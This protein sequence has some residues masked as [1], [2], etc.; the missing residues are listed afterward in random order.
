M[1][2]LV[3][4][5][6]IFPLNVEAHTQQS[7]HFDITSQGQEGN[8]AKW[9]IML[10]DE[11]AGQTIK[12]HLTGHHALNVASLASQHIEVK[13][14]GTDYEWTLPDDWTAQSLT[15]ST[16]LD[17]NQLS[18]VS[19][20]I[21]STLDGERLAAQDTLYQYTDVTGQ[22]T[23]DKAVQ[24]D[25]QDVAVQLVNQATDETVAEQRVQAGAFTFKDV[26]MFNDDGQEVKYIVRVAE[27]PGYKI[28]VD[29]YH[30][31]IQ[32]DK[33]SE[34]RTEETATDEIKTEEATTPS[35][36]E[37]KTDDVT[38]E[39]PT[40]E[41]VTTESPTTETPV[42][43]AA[44]KSIVFKPQMR[45][46]N[47]MALAA[48][49]S[50]YSSTPSASTINIATGT[51]NLGLS[52]QMN[53]NNT[54]ITW[55]FTLDYETLA[56][57]PVWLNDIAVSSGLSMPSSVS[58][59]VVPRSG[60]IKS[61]SK[62]VTTTNGLSSISLGDV[63]Q[64]DF[65]VVTIVT[66]VTT[67]DLSSYKLT[68]GRLTYDEIGY[69]YDRAGISN[70]I[71]RQ[72]LAPTINTVTE[73]AR[74]VT[75]TA[76]AGAVVTLKNASGVTIGTA[77]ADSSGKYSMSISPQ[78]KG[79]VLMASAQ[80]P[81]QI[82][83][84]SVSTTVV[85]L[86]S[87]NVLKVDNNQKPLAGAVFTL[88]GPTTQQATSNSAGSAQFTALQPGTY[89]LTETTAPN[90]YVRN[91]ASKTV[92]VASNGAVTVD[93]TAV[94]GS[95]QYVN[96]PV[97]SS[98]RINAV[99]GLSNK[100]VA[101]ATYELRNAA[102]QLVATQTSD[103]SGVVLFNN[104]PLGNYTVTQVKAP[105]GYQL[106]NSVKSLTVT[107]AQNVYSSPQYSNVLPNT[108]GHGPIAFTISGI[109]I[110]AIAF[111]FYKIK[112]IREASHV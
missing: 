71:T 95:Y 69:K 2:F 28:A 92:V 15:L 20:E 84:D 112:L 10:D 100:G 14:S 9:R 17:M 7:P 99:D 19:M 62:T 87:F 93:G 42:V 94:S 31:D 46:M 36:E 25:L 26:R 51:G 55:R 24:D 5:S 38:T 80:L 8:A 98:I 16:A 30:I 102:G 108:G 105:S 90:G 6:L 29:R 32:A 89:T 106:N 3:L 76:E 101:G 111:V 65:Y 57:K 86:Y 44:P 22:L 73:A 60:N 40:T 81:N 74:L 63:N 61:G 52:S 54:S 45:F 82:A 104:L 49:S 103:S 75:G 4:V 77:T 58:Y 1:L 34:K 78:A 11:M 47:I 79:S 37:K 72:T 109:F 110:M 85:G 64:Y 68:I 59:S 35:T 33:K 43:E 70:T 56:T 88:S 13:P 27:M 21:S 50:T 66:P 53:S 91:T 48:T 41:D 67:P 83:S 107:A 39:E 96:Q 18:D 12:L 97:T 23:I